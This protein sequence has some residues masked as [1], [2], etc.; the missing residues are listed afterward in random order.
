MAAEA[1]NTP[2]TTLQAL[3][4]RHRSSIAIGD[5]Y[6]IIYRMWWPCAQSRCNAHVVVLVKKVL[7]TEM[8][9]AGVTTLKQK[10]ASWV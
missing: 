5:M 10:Y 6:I 1:G 8:S 9:S 3:K 4:D 2:L 7:T